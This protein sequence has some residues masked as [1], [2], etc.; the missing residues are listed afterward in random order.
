MNFSQVVQAVIDIT[1]RPDKNTETERA[2]NAAL[3]FFCIKGEFV[4]DLLEYAITIPS[5][6]YTGQVSLSA[7]TRFRRMKFVNIEGQRNFL[8]QI[9]PEQLF[10]P[11]GVV[12]SNTYYITGTELSYSLAL[13]A[14]KLNLGYY[15]YP[16][17]LTNVDEHWFL[18]AAHPCV[19]DRAAGIIFK[20]IGDD[21]SMNSHMGFANEWYNTFVRDQVQP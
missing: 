1:K 15:S 6:S 4:Q 7:L 21:S 12:Q 13:L 10:T 14:S 8:K 5:T 3:S 20:H 16:P 9:S 2:V 19:I 17:T 18:D 11:G